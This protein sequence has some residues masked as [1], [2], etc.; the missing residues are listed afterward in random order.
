[1]T[2]GN[3]SANK[4][5]FWYLTNRERNWRDNAIVLNESY[6]HVCCYAHIVNLIVTEGLSEME[7]SIVWNAV[8][9]ARSSTTRM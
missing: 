5:A 8:K 6:L 7:Q 9:Y 1:M 4:G 3:T 2:I